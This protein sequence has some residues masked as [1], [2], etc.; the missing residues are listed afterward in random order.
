MADET[1][2]YDNLI[3]SLLT[4]E[5]RLS[6]TDCETIARGQIM[7]FNTSTGKLS[8]YTSQGSNGTNAFFGIAAEASGSGASRYLSVYV[9]GEFNINSL[10]FYYSGD[11]ADQTLINAARDKGCI[12]KTF[13]S[14][15]D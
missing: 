7:A 1:L 6:L 11:S 8:Q 12:L 9:M 15:A 2:Q 14:A 10:S 13:V 5:F 4:R 3:G